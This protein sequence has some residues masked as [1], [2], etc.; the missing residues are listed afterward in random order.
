MTLTSHLAK[1]EHAE[2]RAVPELP[3]ALQVSVVQL[4][5]EFL[6]EL[7]LRHGLGRIVKTG[8]LGSTGEGWKTSI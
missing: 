7:E 4:P 1:V 5:G 2:L 8:G 6:G 3:L